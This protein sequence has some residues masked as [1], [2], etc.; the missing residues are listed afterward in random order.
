MFDSSGIR[1]GGR[2]QVFQNR[3]SQQGKTYIVKYVQFFYCDTQYYL[4]SINTGELQSLRIAAVSNASFLYINDES[5]ETV[6]P[7]V[8]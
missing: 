8:V 6:W 4:C 3:Y 2:V 5:D 7:G 1:V